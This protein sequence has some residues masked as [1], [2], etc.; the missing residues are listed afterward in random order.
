VGGK[1]EIRVVI[2]RFEERFVAALMRVFNN[3]REIA[4]GLMG[5]HAEQQSN[6]VSH[7]V[8]V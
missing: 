3:F 6:W 4:H 5:V 7:D 2:K 1:A 8:S